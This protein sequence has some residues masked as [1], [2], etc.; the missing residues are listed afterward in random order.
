MSTPTA[1]EKWWN[2]YRLAQ[3]LTAIAAL[4]A[5]IALL[6]ITGGA[7]EAR[8]DRPV[9][10]WPAVPGVVRRAEAVPVEVRGRAPVRVQA[11][12]VIYDYEVGG[13]AYTND[14]LRAD[15]RP[16]IATSAAGQRL[17]ALS[18]GDAVMVF[19][20]PADP[21]Q[22]VLERPAPWRGVIN[23]LALLAVA[24]AVALAA[25]LARPAPAGR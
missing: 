13:R 12:R 2:R 11:A 16:V 25:R 24:A 18:P 4:W 5:V 19:A 14:R 7:I 3:T 20:N 21:S 23:G 9:A 8:R 22:A 15:E 1:E 17:L 10:S 6:V